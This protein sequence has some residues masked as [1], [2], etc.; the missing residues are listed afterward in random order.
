ML[1]LADLDIANRHV[2]IREDFNVPIKNGKIM[3]AARIDAALETIQYAIQ[4][5]AKII[6][7]SHLGR[8]EE[9]VFDA[10]YSLHPIAEYLGRRLQ[11]IV[12][13]FQLGDPVPPLLPGQVAM[14]EN[15][16]FLVGESE[17]D[18]GLSQR[19]AALGE[20]F[21]MDAFAV[22]HRAQASTCGIVNYAPQA[23]AGPLLMKELNAL[24]SIF[25]HP[26]KPVVGI[27]GGSKVSTKLDLLD[28]LLDNMDTLILGGGI[29]NTFLAAQG[30]PVGQSLY[31]P[32]RI[33]SAKAL[34]EKAKAMQKTIWVPIDVVV[35]DEIT[36]TAQTQIRDVKEVQPNDKI[37]DIGPRSREQLRN[38]LQDAKTI[39]WNGPVGV[40]ECSPFAQGTK[41]LAMAV[42]DSSAFSVAGGGDTLSAIDTFGVA[43]KISYLSTG[44]GAFLEALE[45]KPLPAVEALQAKNLD[46]KLQ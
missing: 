2:L 28:H 29:A 17:N 24:H 1:T 19:L 20:I 15:V 34:L 31:E 40:F 5:K 25:E 18:P 45:G 6:L 41:A 4:Q 33:E 14:C 36:D 23:V 37:A 12:P 22:A 42:A 13:V 39:V 35:A 32:D 8:P 43:D 11:Q 38:C 9:G 10:Q 7:L 27:V 44:G 16:R 46:L 26:Q 21:V 3:H 30:F